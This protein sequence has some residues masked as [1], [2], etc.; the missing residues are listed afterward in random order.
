MNRRLV[1]AFITCSSLLFL[2]NCNIF[3]IFNI[4]AGYDNLVAQGDAAYEDGD[5]QAAMDKYEAAIK[6]NGRGS[7]ARVGYVNALTRLHF[8]DVLWIAQELSGDMNKVQFA[9][10][11]NN[12][13]VRLNVFSSSGVF[14]ET[15]DKLAP[16]TAGRCDADF[17]SD[18]ISVNLQLAIAYL[19]RGVAL[20][21]DSN[22]DTW[23]GK[24]GDLVVVSDYT[25]PP[26]R[27]DTVT[28]G[29]QKVKTNAENAG[30]VAKGIGLTELVLPF[31]T[32][33]LFLPVI[34]N[35]LLAEN[36][37]MGTNGEYRKFV[38]AY[39]D[40]SE[41]ILVPFLLVD[42]AKRNYVD[43]ARACLQRISGRYRDSNIKM[44]SNAAYLVDSYAAQLDTFQGKY[45]AYYA[46]LDV[47][48]REITDAP[49][50][51]SG[52]FRSFTWHLQHPVSSTATNDNLIE[53]INDSTNG[54]PAGPMRV[55]ELGKLGITVFKG[56]S[57]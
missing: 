42:N 41:G 16:I 44:V 21:A 48:H 24:P 27:L 4:S 25:V 33:S 12:S 49:A 32:R 31:A 6:A 26:F 23:I 45:D 37:T 30:G 14:Q 46:D 38:Q 50:Q 35:P 54:L 9:T 20:V 39:H 34:N 40:A 53:V 3:S 1:W 36:L 19:L 52:T 7:K 28:M 56:L 10:L 11:I 15:I 29:F 55:I 17:E 43:M 47:I 57:Q 18:D 51:T 2:A 5:Y 22:R 8:V 13:H